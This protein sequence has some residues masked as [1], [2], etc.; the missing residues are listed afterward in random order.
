VNEIHDE[1][2]RSLNYHSIIE[3]RL[4]PTED[5][6]ICSCGLKFDYRL[7][8]EQALGHSYKGS[9]TKL[10]IVYVDDGL[11]Y[12]EHKLLCQECLSSWPVRVGRGIGKFGLPDINVSATMALHKS[13]PA[14]GGAGPQNVGGG[15]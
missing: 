11:H 10:I 5:Y 14:N 13:C 7:T 8:P 6:K 2:L 15:L 1:T 9:Q 3:S 4:T 12:L